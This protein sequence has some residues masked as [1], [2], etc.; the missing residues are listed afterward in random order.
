[1][2]GNNEEWKMENKEW[3]MKNL[4]WNLRL[5]SSILQVLK[6]A[7]SLQLFFFG[8]TIKKQPERFC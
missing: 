3:R 1:M 6:F 2:G 5:I 7:I 4:H 8:D